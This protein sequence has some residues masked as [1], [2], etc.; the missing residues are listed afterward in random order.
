[1]KDETPSLNLHRVLKASLADRE[2]PSDPDES[3]S[4]YIPRAARIASAASGKPMVVPAE[5]ASLGPETLLRVVAYC[6]AKGVVSSS[7]IEQRLES[8]PELRA[9][10]G[11]NLPTGG[12]IRRF[13]QWNRERIVTALEAA[14]GEYWRAV[15]PRREAAGG[16]DTMVLA[17]EKAKQ[18][19]EE[20]IL[21][22]NAEADD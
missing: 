5:I 6:Y 1:M 13:R 11:S 17:R 22:D 21:R 18:I 20:A 16:E 14:L 12:D 9:L 4:D 10:L 2:T 3:I 7:D 15:P 8:D 19:L